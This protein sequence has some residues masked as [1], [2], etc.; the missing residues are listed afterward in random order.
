MN[1]NVPNHVGIIMDGNG[2]WATKR[3]LNRTKGHLKGSDVLVEIA[4]CAFNK[5]IKVLSVFAFSTEN[6]N[7]SAEEV[8]FIMNLATKSLKGKLDKL[9][10]N[11]IKVVFSGEKEKLPE[12][13]ISLMKKTELNTIN[14]NAGI[15]NIC[16][17]YGGKREMV[18]ALKKIIAD[19]VETDSLTEKDINKYLYHNLPDIDLVIRT[20]GEFRISNFM[21]WQMAYAELYFTDIC[22]PDFTKEELDKAI[23][24]YNKRNRNFG[25]VSE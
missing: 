12:K 8:N 1:T 10:D 17:N 25:G 16:L 4:E 20:S 18:E 14:N 24:E 5:G 22:W 9:M 7:R 21:L 19:K 13:L 6:F 11:N 3:G 2:R 23:D 15:L